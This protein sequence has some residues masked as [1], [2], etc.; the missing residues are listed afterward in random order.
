MKKISTSNGFFILVDDADFAYLDQFVWRARD[1]YG[2]TRYAVRGR[3]KASTVIMHRMIMDAPEGVEVDHIDGN[4]LNNQRSNLRL[5]SSSENKWNGCKRNW[6]G[7]STLSKYKG[8]TSI[9]YKKKDGTVR[10]RW[11][12]QIRHNWKPI[13]IGMYDTE[14]EAAEAYNEKAVEL[15]NE[16]AKLNELG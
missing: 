9:R 11:V 8:V 2:R 16:F 6:N 3:Y 10:I 4:G 15:F 13:Y 7:K 14:E 1:N 5:C 12:A